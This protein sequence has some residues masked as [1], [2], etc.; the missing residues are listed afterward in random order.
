MGWKKSSTL[1]LSSRPQ[2]DKVT[3]TEEEAPGV[4]EPSTTAEGDA[5]STWRRPFKEESALTAAGKSEI[6]AVGQIGEEIHANGA[7][8]VSSVSVPHGPDV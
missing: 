1:T 5:N 6:N 3:H 4:G 2:P 8:D 7:A